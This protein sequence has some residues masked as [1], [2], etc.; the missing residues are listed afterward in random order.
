MASDPA[1]CAS[2][3]LD[4][5]ASVSG[6]SHRKL[7]TPAATDHDFRFLQH[8][9]GVIEAQTDLVKRSVVTLT[10]SQQLLA[11][12]DNLLRR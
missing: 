8:V 11:K 3:K 1:V 4:N 2:S 5:L 9:R 6:Y 7:A 10:E 12:I